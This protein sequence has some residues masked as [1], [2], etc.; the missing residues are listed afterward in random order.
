[1]QGKRSNYDTD[2]FQPIMHRARQLLGHNEQQMQENIVAY[3]VIAD[4]GRAMTWLLADRVLPS[5]ERQGYVLRMIMRRAIRFGRRLGFELPFLGEVADAVIELMG[6][7]FPELKERRALILNTVA[8]EEERFARTLDAGL[9]RLHRLLEEL[10]DQS[11]FVVPGEEAFRLH[12]TYGFPLELTRDI[13]QEDGFTVDEAGFHAAMEQQR[14]RAR[15]GS[16]F[17]VGSAEAFQGITPTTFL[18]YETTSAEGT[19]LAVRTIADDIWVALDRTPFYAEGGGQIGDTGVL[20]SDQLRA[21]VMDTQWYGDVIGHKV[22]IEKGLLAEGMRVQ[23]EVNKE[24]RDAIRR[25]H[26]A[27]HLLHA[28]L[29]R[30]LG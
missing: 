13:A 1:L 27:T 6:D 21:E 3:R 5:D 2:L 7:A 16:G 19:V 14:E 11:E 25:A 18:G 15:A 22:K 20:R 26:T 12:D 10:R 17:R 4:H 30:V 24:R 9:E 23:A 29:R 8:Q 28:A